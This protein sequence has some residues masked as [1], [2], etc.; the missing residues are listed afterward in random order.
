MLPKA[1]NISA[2]PYE[3]L[4]EGMTYVKLEPSDGYYGFENMDENNKL[5]PSMDLTNPNNVRRLFTKDNLYTKKCYVIIRINYSKNKND[6]I[7][8]NIGNFFR[9]RRINYDTMM[10]DVGCNCTCTGSGRVA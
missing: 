10:Y 8:N 1:L 7:T 6:I 2:T 5:C 4:Y 9:T 3:Q